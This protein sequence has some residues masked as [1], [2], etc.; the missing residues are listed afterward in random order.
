MIRRLR[1]WRP[2]RPQRG[3][4]LAEFALV[5]PIFLLLTFS[6]VQFGMI[7]GAQDGLSNAVREATRYASTVPVA[8]KNDAGTCSAGVGQQVY[9]KL[10]SSLAAK[11]PGYA[12]A[13]LVACGQPAP[14]S[15]VTYCTRLNP[16]NTYAIFVQVQAVYRHPLYLPIVGAIVDR[17]D[18]T[19]DNHLR[20]TATEQMRVETFNL[21]DLQAS[22]FLPCNP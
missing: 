14:A 11:V 5:I 8:N 13:D 10:L 3:Q 4:A 2:K 20:A 6:V 19:A 21:T 15:S 22:G 12:T 1:S 9:S 16:D 17:L 7:L 18:G